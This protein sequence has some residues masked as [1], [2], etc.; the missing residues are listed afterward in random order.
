MHVDTYWMQSTRVHPHEHISK[1]VDLSCTQ[2][3]ISASFMV[4]A[5]L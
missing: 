4:L 1:Q 3:D 2:L 5:W